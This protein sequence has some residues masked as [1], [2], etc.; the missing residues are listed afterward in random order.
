MVEY[1]SN[2]AAI[3][4]CDALVDRI[5]AG[6]GAGTLVMYD[7]SVPADADTA[8]SGNNVLA[9]LTFSDPA[10]GAA[11][12]NTPGALATASAITSDTS[13]N[14]GTAT[15]ARIFDSNSLIVLQCSVG[16]TG[17]DINLNS[18]IFS[19]GQTVAL[20]SLTVEVEES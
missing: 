16:T 3:V 11:G 20:T 19:A 4:L 6:A 14:A 13:A 2:A 1:I 8:L 10:F 12:D 17:E 18:V 9:T 7:G 15:F 5:D